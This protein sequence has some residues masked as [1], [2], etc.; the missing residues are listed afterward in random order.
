[1]ATQEEHFLWTK[2][3][4]YAQFEYRL[5]VAEAKRWAF[6]R[7]RAVQLGA[8]GQRVVLQAPRLVAVGGERHGATD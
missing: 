4:L 5:S 7:W 6:Q 2:W 3:R 1:M 8:T